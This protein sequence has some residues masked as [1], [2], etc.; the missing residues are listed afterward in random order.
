MMESFRQTVRNNNWKTIHRI[1]HT[2]PT[3]FSKL[4]SDLKIKKYKGRKSGKSKLS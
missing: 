3:N 2:N 4:S 1:L